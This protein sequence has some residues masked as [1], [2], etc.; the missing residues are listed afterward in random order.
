MLIANVDKVDALSCYIYSNQQ[1]LALGA[2]HPISI[3]MS[4][5]LV[6]Y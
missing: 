5:S 2:G 3:T 1:P 4:Y 6:K